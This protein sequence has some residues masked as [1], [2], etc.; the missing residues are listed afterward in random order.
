MMIVMSYNHLVTALLLVDYHLDCPIIILLL[1]CFLLSPL[2]S[3]SKL[4]HGYSRLPDYNCFMMFSVLLIV[5]DGMVVMM[6]IMIMMMVMVMTMTTTTM[7]MATNDDYDGEDFF[8]F[9]GGGGGGGGG[10]TV[11]R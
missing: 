10:V 2:P 7:M 8:S 11:L 1:L 5:G 9:F 4:Y 3:T 6:M